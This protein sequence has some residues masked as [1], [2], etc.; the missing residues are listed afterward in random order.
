[1]NINSLIL[2]EKISFGRWVTMATEVVEKLTR[3]FYV[4]VSVYARNFFWHAG[5]GM[6]EW[7]NRHKAFEREITALKHVK[8]LHLMQIVGS[9][10]DQNFLAFP[11]EPV[12]NC[13]LMDFLIHTANCTELPAIRSFYGCLASTV[14][15][16]HAQ[17]VF[18]MNLK[19]QNILIKE[20]E[21]Y[22]AD[23]GSAHD[24]S[25]QENSTSRSNV[26]KTARY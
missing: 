7:L 24:W 5:T 22:I 11:M 23:F 26:P 3:S 21:L 17:Q 15:Y 19:P 18:H 8:H 13:N 20:G 25:K 14:A 1:M 4:S 10:L 16:L 6:R 12:A 9:Y 2:L